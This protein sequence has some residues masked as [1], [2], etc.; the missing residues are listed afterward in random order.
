MRES[1]SWFVVSLSTVQAPSV[2]QR[3]A[4]ISV[5]WHICM[6]NTIRGLHAPIRRQQT[7]LLNFSAHS[8]CLNTY[9]LVPTWLL[10]VVHFLKVAGWLGRLGHSTIS[11]VCCLL[12]LFYRIFIYN[13]WWMLR[14][15]K[16]N[17]KR[18]SRKELKLYWEA[19]SVNWTQHAPRWLYARGLV[20]VATRIGAKRKRDKIDGLL[21]Q[22]QG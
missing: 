6:D 1:Y 22:E 15:R 11:L 20:D 5:L 19:T 18:D 14:N 2:H 17:R 9:V 12:V 10:H 7:F 13:R 8:F 21:Q 4:V 3:F 16:R